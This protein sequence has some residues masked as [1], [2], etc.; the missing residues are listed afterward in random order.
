[1]TNPSRATV[2]ALALA[3]LAG[4]SGNPLASHPSDYGRRIASPERAREVEAF[5]P[6]AY[7]ARPPRTLDEAAAEE[8]ERRA[9]LL[10]RDAERARVEI[11]IEDVRAAALSNNLDLRVALV[12]P[13]IAQARLSEEEAAF[14]AAFT[15]D[16]RW[17]EIDAA[18][19]TDLASGQARV[20]RLVPAVEVPLRT[21]GTA[22][23]ALPMSR[24]SDNNQFR[25]LNPAYTSDLEFT[26][27][28]QLLRGAG[29][30][31]NTH[32][33]RVAS[34]DRRIGLE[35]T[36]LE[37][38]RQLANADRAYWRLFRARA[39]L[40]VAQQQLELA[41]AQLERAE[42]QARAGT[43]PEIEVIRAEAGVASRLEAIFIAQ[44]DVLRTQRELKRLINAPDLDIGGSASLV[45]TTDPEPVELLF[46]TEALAAAALDRRV[47]LLEIELRLAQD[48]ST[49]EFTSNQSLPLLT[50]DYTYR[51]NGLGGSLEDSFDLMTDRDFA[52]WELGLRARIP[53]GNEAAKSRVRAAIL[54]RMQRLRT[55]EAREQSIR[56]EVYDAVDQL[57]TTWQR[58][59]SARQ[60]VVLNTR[61]LEAEQRQFGVGRSTSNDVLE[62]AARLA[63]AQ[64]AEIRAITDYQIAKIDLAVATGMLLGAAAVRFDEPTHEPADFRA[65][66]EAPPSDRAEGHRAGLLDLPTGWVEVRPEAPAPDRG[67]E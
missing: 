9:G 36:K 2:C 37:A 3:T 27:S 54:T 40:E 55:R 46:D 4:C 64:V 31:A 60:S 67:P 48:A 33:I 49:I 47:E 15:A 10:A 53:I 45:T 25:T 66:I 28:Q 5:H 22:R 17:Q 62:A 16:F 52:D 29:R 50:V 8:A 41:Q 63:D 43:V 18:T 44:A 13:A 23:V 65:V 56:Q 32:A 21:G 51:L 19:A 39:E 34:Y 38:I 59:L 6:E 24:T 7:L 12:A 35:Q 58:V 42:R 30:R 20:Q 11:S 1:M 14:E 57:R 61:S 26:I